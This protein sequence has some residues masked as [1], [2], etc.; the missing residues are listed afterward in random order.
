M[1]WL[2]LVLTLAL[3]STS[4][5]DSGPIFLIGNHYKVDSYDFEVTVKDVEGSPT[6]PDTATAPPLSASAAIRSAQPIVHQLT[7]GDDRW[8]PGEITL[9]RI[10][11]NW[12]VYVVGFTPPPPT[13]PCVVSTSMSYYD[14]FRV[15]VLMNGRVIVPKFTQ[16]ARPVPSPCA[17]LTTEPPR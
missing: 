2:A 16:G 3:Q 14:T 17:T 10:H 15:V 8:Q 7:P 12:W 4:P 5:A 6:W 1:P 13:P 9:R 11:S